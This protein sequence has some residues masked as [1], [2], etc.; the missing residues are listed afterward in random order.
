MAIT[1][2]FNT[3]NV[4]LTLTPIIYDM[5]LPKMISMNYWVLLKIVYI[6]RGRG[7]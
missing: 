7:R 4:K 5:I 3:L 2:L 1:K 6:A